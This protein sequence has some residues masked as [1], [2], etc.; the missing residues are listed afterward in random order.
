MAWSQVQSGD[1]SSYYYNS[2][3][4]EMSNDPSVMAVSQPITP[5]SV[6][7][8]Y[9]QV[10][11]TA[12]TQDWINQTVNA[13][14]G[15]PNATVANVI[16]DTTTAAAASGTPFTNTAGDPNS[17]ASGAQYYESQG[18]VPGGTTY[19]GV[20]TS[21]IDPKTGQV[22]AQYGVPTAD[23]GGTPTSYAS[24][25]FQWNETSSLP[26][27]TSVA[28]A[29]P[30][31]D[32][33]TGLLDAVKGIGYVTAVL[34][35]AGALDA[36]LPEAVASSAEA[37]PV[38]DSTITSSELAPLS[39]ASVPP[40]SPDLPYNIPP[41]YPVEPAP[42]TWTPPP[43]TPVDPN[44]IPPDLQPNQPE[45]P[46]EET[47]PEETPPT[48]PTPSPLTPS[49]L[50]K[51]ASTLAPLA[52][53]ALSPSSSTTSSGSSG[54]GSNLSAGNTTINSSLPGNL[55]ATSLQAGNVTEVD[56]FKDFDVYKQI[57]PIYAASGGKMTS[58]PSPLQLTQMTQG[59]TGIDP[60]LFSVLQQRTMPNYFSYGQNTS[61]QPTQ[62]IGNS[63]LSR[64]SSGIPTLS[65]ANKNTKALYAQS[66]ADGLGIGSNLQS[67]MMAHG[68][69][70]HR[71]DHVPEFITGATGHYVK[72]R[73]DGQ[74]DD[75][76]AMLAD[77]E[78]VFDADTVAALGNGSSDAGAAVLDKMREAIRAHKRSAS[79][80]E[81]PP[82]AKSPLEYLKEG[83]K[84]KGKRK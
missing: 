41:D 73:G 80:N 26:K 29:I 10:T 48:P 24:N 22:V 44:Q 8:A 70:A 42:D 58:Q 3:T 79:V 16:R 51:A 36:M 34:G 82:K 64:P 61:S 15:D 71:D 7:A 43:E 52:K 59:I 83:M 72:G 53:A 25:Q 66:G 57:E 33:N 37:F 55:T 19:E 11:G 35:G 30:Q 50:A 54:G 21:Y 20:P 45:T 17:F 1:G 62:L 68:G 9:T 6:A 84:H 65:N 60:R 18:Y 63:N 56:P 28:L 39:D 23:Q 78:Y 14:Q 75:I 13:Y 77:G 12:P 46:P 81:I 76:P 5:E 32:Y 74:S 38:A 47:P 4:G 31:T 27:D 2:D 67:T 69:E 49:N 40:L